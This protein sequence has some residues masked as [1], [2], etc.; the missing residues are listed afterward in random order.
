MARKIIDIGTIGN[1]GTGDS[2]RDSFRKVNDN[3]RELYSSL[4]LGE[5]LTFIGLSD[6]RFDAQTPPYNEN[7]NGYVGF[8][9]AILT[10]NRD[11]SGISFKQ[12]IAGTGIQI[13]RT[14]SDTEI[15]I[16]TLFA[17]IS[18]DPSP[19]LGGDLSARGGA[20][21][22]RIKD[23]GTTIDPLLPIF[24]HEAVNKAYADTK[25]SRAGT[26]AIDPRTG[27]N[28]P[29][30]GRMTGPLILSRDP[31]PDDD[32]IF[33]GLIAASKRYV[34]SSAFGSAVNLYVATS[35]A[36]ERPG[37]SSALQGRALAYAYRTLEAALKRAEELV[38]ES[39][40]DIGPYKKILT[41]NQGEFKCTLSSI[42]EAPGSG[43]GFDGKVFMSVDTIEIFRNPDNI[44]IRGNN[45]R[46]G[47][48][49]ELFGG[50]PTDVPC[51]LEVLSTLTNP[52][53][54]LTFRVISAGVYETLPSEVSGGGVPATSNSQFGTGVR[55]AVTYK[56]NKVEVLNGGSGY[57]LVSVRFEPDILDTTGSGA[58][59][60][61]DVVDGEVISITLDDP[62][63]RFTVKPEVVVN[64]PRFKIFTGGLRT[65]FTGDVENPD[66]VAARTR[67]VREGLYL[68]GEES[69]AL[70]QI[71]AHSGELDGL[72]EIF[73]V[74]IK[75]GR[76]I[77]G[78]EIAYGDVTKNIQITVLIE[79]GIY[80][81]NY[82][83]RVPQN[84]A[85][86]GDEFR[87]VL[88]KPKKGESSSPWAFLNFRRE[89]V[90]DELNV[91]T[92]LFGYHYLQE[93]TQPVYPLVDN[94]GSY[95]AA[96]NL[97]SL[98]KSFVQSEAISWINN[99]IDNN[100]TPFIGFQYDDGVCARDIGLIIDSLI[101]DLRYG[102]YSR[103]VSA[104]LKYRGNASGRFA[105]DP[106]GQLSQTVA[107][108]EKVKD[109][110]LDIIANQ[111]ITPIYNTL[112]F[113]IIDEGFV[114]ETGS[115]AVIVDLIDSLIDI[116]EDSGAV[117]YPKNNDQIDVF[118]CNDAVILRA[119]TMQGH[120][121]FSMVLDPDG[122]I[123]AKSPY[124]Q[125]CASF[126]KSTG[127]KT[128]AGGMFVD[129]FT[130]NLQFR[131]TERKIVEGSPSNIRLGVSGLIKFPNLP[132]SFIVND[133]VYRINYVRDFT[134][135]PTGST[136]TF[137]LDEVTPFPYPIGEQSI[138]TVTPG[139]PGNFFKLNHFLQIG[140]TIKFTTTGTFPEGLEGNKEYFVIAEGFNP[141]NFTVTDIPGSINGVEITTVGTGT[142]SY[143]RI[144]EVLM[145]GNRSML[146]NDFTQIADLG[147]GLIA[148]NGGLT[149]AVSMFTYYCHISYYSLNGGQI[150]SIGGSSAH[151]DYALVAE[152][153]DPLEIPTPV[154][155]YYDLGQG[156]RC[157]FPTSLYA[158]EVNGLIIYVDGYDYVPLS[159]SELEV[160]HTDGE[161]YRY[162]INSADT[163]DLPA[164]V[165]KLTLSSTG[166][167][168]TAG[169]AAVVPDNTPLSIRQNSQVILT[170][171]VVEVATRPSTALVLNESSSVY[172]ILQFSAFNDADGAQSVTITPGDPATIVCA[173]HQQLA[174]YI[175]TFESVGGTLPSELSEG[176]FYYVLETGLATNSFLISE[177]P[178]GNPLEITSAGT[179]TI[180][181]QSGG[182]ARTT[183]R[184]NYDYVDITVLTPNEFVGT[185]TV[186]TITIATPAVISTGSAHG[187][188]AGDVIR[189][190]TTGVLPTGINDGR[191][192]HVLSTG[193]T[194]TSFQVSLE[195]NGPAVDTS[196]T[197]SGTHRFGKVKGRIG[198]NNFAVVAV[199][200]GDKSR[201]RSA[202]Y[203]FVWVGT[204]YTI[205]DYEDESETGEAYGRITFTPA[206][207]LDA[208]SGKGD[209]LKFPA[210]PTLKAGVPKRTSGANGSLTIRISLTRVTSHDLL[211]IG[212]GSYADTNYPNEIYGPP[213][214]A[215]DDSKETQERGSGRTF[216]VTTDQFGNFRVGPYFRVDQGT[217]TVTFSAAIALSNLDGLGF[218]RGVPIA[219][220]SVDGTMGDNAT[221]TVPTENAV[222]TYVDKRLGV[223]HTGD[224]LEPEE[225]IPIL[226]GGFMSLG[227][228]TPMKTTMN[229]NN[230]NISNVADPVLDQDAVNL[231]SLIFNN[232]QEMSI[233]NPKAGDI[234]AFT[235]TGDDAVNVSVTGDIRF[236]NLEPGIDS[237]IGTVNVQI[238]DETIVNSDISPSAAIAQSKLILNAATT[239]ANATGIAQADRG[240]AS[241][242]SGVF[243]ATNG[244]IDLAD[245]GILLGKLQQ[246]SA[247]TAL[248]YSGIGTGTPTAVPF[249]TIIADGDGISKTQY[250]GANPGGGGG[251]Y[252]RGTVLFRR[253]GFSGTGALS[254]T[255]YARISL[256]SNYDGTGNTIIIRDNNG[257][258]EARTAILQ[259]VRL[260]TSAELAGAGTLALVRSTSSG[261]GSG[262]HRLYGW[263]GQGGVLVGS[264]TAGV[265]TANNV[266]FYDNNQ[267]H[268]RQQNP[269]LGDA[270]IICSQVTARAITTGGDST[271]GT[272]T[273]QWTLQS[274]P[275]GTA[276]K[277]N[278]RLQ[279][280][281]AADLAEFYEGDKDYDVGTVLVFGGEK[282]VTISTAHLDT[283][284]A[285]V[286]SNNAAFSMYA[287]CPGYKNQVALQGRVPCRVVGKINK[288]DI[289][290]TSN[291]PGV[292]V[293]TKD[294]KPGTIIG[295][296]LENYDSDH[297]GMIEVAVGRT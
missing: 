110:L 11:E 159:N 44:P 165:A 226:S 168:A 192:Y 50:A 34:D 70:A 63:S 25:L 219:E 112:R 103:T 9:N 162:A 263:N 227:L 186:C 288:G 161:I 214:N 251:I 66:P 79:S 7:G 222:R 138:T 96:A 124:S 223:S 177:N 18:N 19:Q 234:L 1:D 243:N 41:Y 5:R 134:Y 104:A 60:T 26:D 82:P 190:I 81:E 184:E 140:A 48:I 182:L 236:G 267:H 22:H 187:L 240:L 12:I 175:V 218:K 30:F 280:T 195:P 128:F 297:I 61:A 171:D 183:L 286:V 235:G 15:E 204:E 33:D 107:A 257:D 56:V 68:R 97:L 108:I 42:S 239:R 247:D 213:V 147:Y 271:T 169:L 285:G 122:Q 51:R 194:G 209:V 242:N 131:L 212:T 84:V 205:T 37:V 173:G 292:A 157:Y 181:I 203:K 233:T 136:A 256:E 153:A 141:N 228:P 144:Y 99:Q 46:V 170:G 279:A 255:H 40:V 196:D 45:Y 287:A 64:L 13:D 163:T 102:G 179:G 6:V 158:N 150:R 225:T 200:P 53:G 130:G 127:L 206:L 260:R 55:F 221:D 142:L 98:N 152:G 72:D 231:R 117:N 23:L 230:N 270:P 151:G 167:T 87:R 269:S 32:E 146:S 254:D 105:I 10:V 155:L 28:N 172:R 126:S 237:S 57:G 54:V 8:E 201:L 275:G 73:D 71:L 246:I 290:V 132:A 289:M 85:I 244:W 191:H 135:S 76:F 36:D 93:S 80:E 156:A 49:I 31:E 224:V 259:D 202:N 148:T 58:F 189:F 180:T 120:G 137:V 115:D 21:Q 43:S 250:S 220:F 197:Q 274:T 100:L 185:P 109:Y 65:D 261:G 264:D 276:G 74:D 113:Q 2:I 188:F 178:N 268:F 129:G 262:T 210:V 27:F 166:N 248:G 164:G 272:I 111:E 17:E 77:E 90:I 78:E 284:V 59:G 133:N 199:G 101:F 139:N 92:Q 283:R 88:I 29:D 217:G 121:G 35:G 20:V 249:S 89:T 294:P 176:V 296:A 293:A 114:A 241:F 69:G 278:S 258:Y 4:G 216:Y 211:E 47:D 24:Q 38:L 145:P 265:G 91:T 86:V 62:G 106:S 160:I 215:L 119:M 198:D 116:I 39:R 16:S 252:G 174:G 149:E 94:K 52:G 238:V 266:T 83:L 273:G 232:F 281:Y 67:D 143:E 291:I 123:L 207:Q 229:L 95:R 277:G 282:E 193:L 154:S 118:L 245:N 253:D 14:T 208:V 125:E 295:K 75:F 3:F